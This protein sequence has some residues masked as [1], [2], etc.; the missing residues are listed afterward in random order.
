MNGEPVLEGVEHHPRPR[1]PR[2][3]SPAGPTSAPLTSIV[4]PPLP[5][6][7][8]QRVRQIQPAEQ[9]LDGVISVRLARQHP[10]E[11]VRLGVGG[12]LDRV[13]RSRLPGD[14]RR[15]L[16]AT[17]VRASD[18]APSR[19]IGRKVVPWNAMAYDK[20]EVVGDAE[21]RERGHDRRL[22]LADKARGEL[23]RDPERPEC[24]AA[25]G[26]RRS[27]P[28]YRRPRTHEERAARW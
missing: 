27:P 23:H 11:Q 22:E 28:G 21:Q 24:P 19:M 7:G 3:S 15:S 12:D 25:A 5:P 10:K 8:P 18:Q 4:T 14:R 16:S 13:G 26:R 9:R 20:R 1:A 6:L 17:G 2:G